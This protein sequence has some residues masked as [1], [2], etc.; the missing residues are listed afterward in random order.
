MIFFRSFNFLTKKTLLF[1]IN[2]II[3]SMA[4]CLYF[5]ILVL[6]KL[7]SFCC[8]YKQERGELLN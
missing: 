2:G 8:F 4:T 1:D 7:S 3:F 5:K 6:L